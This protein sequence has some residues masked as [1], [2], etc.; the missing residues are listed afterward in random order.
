MVR[1]VDFAQRNGDVSGWTVGH[2][3]RR[4]TEV[5][6]SSKSMD[7]YHQLERYSIWDVKTVELLVE[8]LLQSTIVFTCVAGDARGSVEH[9]LVWCACLSMLPVYLEPARVSGGAL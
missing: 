7:H 8:Q 6:G 1:A 5:T 3:E 4:G 9:S 2:S